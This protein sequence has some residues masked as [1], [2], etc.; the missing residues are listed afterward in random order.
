MVEMT[1]GI[2]LVALKA[3]VGE[4]GPEVDREGRGHFGLFKN[5]VVKRPKNYKIVY[6]LACDCQKLSN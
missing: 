1:G 5:L 4:V 3:E 2:S 6:N